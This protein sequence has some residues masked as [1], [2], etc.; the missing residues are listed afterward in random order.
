MADADQAAWRRH[1][2]EDVEPAGLR[3][4]LTAGTLSGCF[5]AT[6]A[7]HGDAPALE[8]DG[9]AA[10]HGE[11]DDR[12][13]R[14]AGFLRERGVARGDRVLLCAPTSLELVV[15]YL[16]TLR[17]GATAMPCDAAL[18]SDELAHLLGDARPAAAFVAPDAREPLDRA[19][20]VA[21]VVA[22]DGPGD[23]IP[24]A[25]RGAGGAPGRARARPRAGDAGLHVRHHRAAEGR[26]AHAG[27]RAG[28]DPRRNAGVALDR[29]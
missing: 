24:D 1:L 6:A 25:G 15:A 10:S 16:G 4:R 22:I 17:M 5:A 9:A 28:F 26:P 29:R 13:A 27:Q 12:A 18:T 14:V 21:T 8:V 23:G 19:G 20:S 3:E 7:E 2:G 11:L